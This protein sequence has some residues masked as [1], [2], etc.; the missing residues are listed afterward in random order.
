[1]PSCMLMYAAG[2]QWSVTAFPC[3]RLTG[4][5]PG[6]KRSLVCVGKRVNETAINEQ[7][8]ARH[9]SPV[10]LSFS[11]SASQCIPSGCVQ[12]Q[13]PTLKFLK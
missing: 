2:C 4:G 10:S 1:M 6:L 3:A 12:V 13:R 8:V 7:D 9:V 5:E 11:L